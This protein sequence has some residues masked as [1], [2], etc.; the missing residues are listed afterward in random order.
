[1]YSDEKI[2]FCVKVLQYS[3][4]YYGVCSAHIENK[5][6]LVR[7]SQLF[8]R[9]VLRRFLFFVCLFFIFYNIH[10]FNHILQYIYPSPFAGASPPLAFKLSGKNL[11]RQSATL[12]QAAGRNLTTACNTL[13]FSWIFWILHALANPF[14]KTAK[15]NLIPFRAETKGRK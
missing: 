6:N 12:L 11:E 15:R 4:F 1:M 3:K 10:S 2:P 7:L 13:L 5:Y 9:N 14:W 8:L